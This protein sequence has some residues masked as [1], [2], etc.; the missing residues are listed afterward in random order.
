MVVVA[1]TS[2]HAEALRSEVAAILSTV[3]LRL[4]EEKTRIVH[5]DE[6]F[7][8]LGFRIQRQIKRG[9]TEALRLHLAV[10]EVIRF[11][12]GQGEAITTTGNEQSAHRPPAPVE[13]GVAGMDQLLPTRRVEGNIRLSPGISWRR[14]SA[15][16]AISIAA[17]PG[18]S[19]DAATSLGGGRAGW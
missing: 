11:G 16:Y 15:G 6:G 4:T 3:G 7:D 18:R 13:S 10:E 2:A 8:F 19:C 5:I 14:V 9:S 17:S 12:E 1:G